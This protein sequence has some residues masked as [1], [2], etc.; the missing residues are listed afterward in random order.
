MCSESL[1]AMGGG[2]CPW[3][4]LGLILGLRWLLS[5]DYRV[6]AEALHANKPPCTS[7]YGQRS[8]G[9]WRARER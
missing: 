1:V 2:R 5:N 3:A 9:F 8:H 7:A 4:L 6:E